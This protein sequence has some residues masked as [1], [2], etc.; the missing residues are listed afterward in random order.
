MPRPANPFIEV[1]VF[2]RLAFANYN[3][4]SLAIPPITR[5]RRR[6]VMFRF[7][8]VFLGLVVSFSSIALGDDESAKAPPLSPEDSIATMTVADGYSLVPVLSEPHIHE[9]SAI[10]WDG[11]G[12]MYVA[13][14]RTYMQDIDGN[15]QLKPTSRHPTTIRSCWHRLW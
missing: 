4:A 14:M 7:V 11:N 8:A 6:S 5:F 9:P 15:D 2:R 3:R 12:R 1:S 10:A 13:E